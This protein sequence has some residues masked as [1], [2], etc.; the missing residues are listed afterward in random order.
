MHVSNHPAEYGISRTIFGRIWYG[1][2]LAHR[3]SDARD[4]SHIDRADKLTLY[5]AV[6]AKDVD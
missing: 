3:P 4:Y 6:L 5:N 1:H 2:S